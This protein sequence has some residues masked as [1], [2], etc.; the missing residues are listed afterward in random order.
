MNTT[1]AT[2]SLD[3]EEP[4]PTKKTIAIVGAGQAGLQLGMSLLGQ[5]DCEVIIYSDRTAE[6]VATGSLM[7]TA[8]LFQGKREIERE[9]GLDFWTDQGKEVPGIEIEVRDEAANLALSF[10]APF[11]D[12]PGM[13]VDFRLKFPEW[14]REYERRGGKLVIQK[15]GTEELERLAAENDLV[16][17]A[18]GKG[19]L[20]KVFERDADRSP[21]YSAPMR[22][23]AAVIVDRDLEL[24]NMAISIVPGGAEVVLL[25]ILGP[26]GKRSTAILV[27]SQKD[28]V[29]MEQYAEIET[30]ANVLGMCIDCAQRFL[31]KYAAGLHG[32]ELADERSHLH[33]AF[34]PVVKKPVGRLPSGAIV[35]GASDC[36]TLVDPICG[37][38]LNNAAVMSKILARRI[39]EHDG[40][41]DEDWMNASFDEFWE[42]GKSVY[43]FMRALLE[44][45]THFADALGPASQSKELAADIINGYP[46]PVGFAEWM[47]NER[48]ARSHV[49]WRS[50]SS[51]A[52]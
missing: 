7:A 13:A 3:I 46:D 23:I 35:M 49:M 52:A 11:R 47:A 34:T 51:V 21:P 26:T 22:H 12:G 38:G 43:V 28:T 18:A 19:P 15:T 2:K 14:M 29:F 41:F 10:D 4:K 16:V 32:A 27:F 8:I 48:A 6:E 24:E 17:V 36:L 31:P 25:P 30:G 33:G 50:R 44:Q 9:L 42:Y 20:S 40:S 5:P 1:T 39:A 37:N 45:P